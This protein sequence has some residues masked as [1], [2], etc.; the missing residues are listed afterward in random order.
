LQRKVEVGRHDM[1][2]S[3]HGIEQLV[4]DVARFK[5]TEAK[6]L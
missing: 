1:V 5:G 4:A 2:V 3:D 6:S